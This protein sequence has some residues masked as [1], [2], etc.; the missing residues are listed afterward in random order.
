MMYDTKRRDHCIVGSKT[1]VE[2][3]STSV[4]PMV[5]DG[6]A[7]LEEFEPGVPGER[8]DSW[9]DCGTIRFE[10]SRGMESKEDVLTGSDW[11][12]SDLTR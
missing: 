2:F 8:A 3:Y 10:K 6:R 9:D 1:W 11:I 4:T 7:N 12:C 5:W